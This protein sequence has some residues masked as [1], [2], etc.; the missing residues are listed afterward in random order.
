MYYV[1]NFVYELE[2]VCIYICILFRAVQYYI[3][4]QKC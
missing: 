1:Y 2:L 3:I 4:N